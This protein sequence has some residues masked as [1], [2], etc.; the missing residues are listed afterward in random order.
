MS[1]HRRARP[2]PARPKK[3]EVCSD[4]VL[5]EG[6]PGMNPHSAATGRGISRRSFLAS[7]GLASAAIAASPMLAACGSGGA[8]GASDTVK[9]WDMIWGPPEYSGAA[10][11]L[12]KAYK[13]T[14]GRLPATYQTIPWANFYQT[15]ASAIASNTGPAVSTG[16]AFMPYQFA[17]QGAIAYADNVLKQ[18]DTDDFLPGTIEALKTDKGYVG[19]PWNSEIR[20]LWYRK[21]LLEKAGAEVPT[22]WPSYLEAGR[23]VARAGYVAFGTA[24]GGTSWGDQTINSLLLN[25]GGGLFN[26]AGEPDC[27]TDR[28][29]ETI[30]FIQQMVRD[31]MV[32]PTAVSQ[33]GDNLTSAW[34]DGKIAMGYGGSF[35][36]IRVGAKDPED[37][38]LMDPLVGPHGDKGTLQYLASVMMYTNTPSQEASD[39]FVKFYLDS[40]KVFWEKKLITSLPVRRS[41]AELPQFKSDSQATKA[42]NEWVPIAKPFQS[43][44]TQAFPALASIDGTS[45]MQTF[46][47]QVFQ[48]KSKPESILK[49]FQSTLE[50]IVEKNS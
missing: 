43:L 28:N 2:S 44:A 3:A 45:V 6:R 15:F 25:N 26:E 7:A 10:K 40:M 23:K 47:Q 35:W 27:V 4:P 41:I 32:D 38:L 33:S 46:A 22:D 42:V 13:P 50:P 48:A 49:S 5:E 12:T 8:G 29:I 39:A 30:E 16:S 14:G 20:M 31:G 21:S 9:F 24:A 1:S 36:Q 17:E 11:S 18:L 34:A 19:V 37:I